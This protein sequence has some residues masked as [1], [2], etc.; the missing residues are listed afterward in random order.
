M[1]A[2]IFSSLVYNKLDACNKVKIGQIEN[3][4]R[5]ATKKIFSQSQ[6][7]IAESL[8]REAFK[9]FVMSNTR[10]SKEQALAKLTKSF[11]KKKNKKI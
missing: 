7:F 8:R 10:L 2:V 5:N 3:H 6:H 11:A 4:P 9:M 1:A